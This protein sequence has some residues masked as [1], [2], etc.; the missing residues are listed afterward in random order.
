MKQEDKEFLKQLQKEMLT[1]DTVCQANPRFWAVMQ[2]IR[3]Y[4]VDDSIDGICIYDIRGCEN[5]YEGEINENL[6]NWLKEEF[7]FIEKIESD[8]SSIELFHGM[9][10]FYIDSIEEIKYFLNI[11]APNK[12]SVCYYRDRDGIAENTMF[13]TLIECKEHIQKNGYHY[14]NPR[15]YA[16]TAWRS[17]QVSK[18]YEILEKTDWGNL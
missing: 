3:D 17:P 9:E 16:M 10:D 11:H 1:Q 7:D 5:V 14:K 12:Y 18:L 8:D 13:L 4:W 6:A 2:T 15:S